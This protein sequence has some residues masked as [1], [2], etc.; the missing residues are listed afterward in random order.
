MAQRIER[1]RAWFR[2]QPKPPS[3]DAVQAME[4]ERQR[5]LGAQHEEEVARSIAVRGYYWPGETEADDAGPQI[6]PGS[7]E[8]SWWLRW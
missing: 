4:D 5:R 7:T 2:Q 6:M 8:G 1:W 3:A